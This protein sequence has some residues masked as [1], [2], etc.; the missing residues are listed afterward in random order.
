MGHHG[1][2]LVSRA[3][4][5]FPYRLK[6][7]LTASLL[8]APLALSGTAGWA[9]AA[10]GADKKPATQ[11][12][13]NKLL[14]LASINMCV[15][16]KE[17][18]ALKT[19]L[20]ANV[21]PIVAYFDDQHGLKLAG[22]NNGKPLSKNQFSLGSTLQLLAFVEGRCSQLLPDEYKKAIKEAGTALKASNGGNQ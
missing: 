22:V 21:T 20:A 19:A 17:K 5:S 8:V 9:Q 6:Q 15:L 18:V 4:V 13:I 7:L 10:S 1:G 16:A 3:L 12:E 11:E 14:M 2:V